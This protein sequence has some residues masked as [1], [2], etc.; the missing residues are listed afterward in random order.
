MTQHLI[1]MPVV[2]TILHCGRKL[3]LLSGQKEQK[4]RGS[5]NG[6]AQ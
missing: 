2:I 5:K 6:Y 4:E 1:I 3:N